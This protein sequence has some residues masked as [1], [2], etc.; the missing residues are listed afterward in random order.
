MDNQK[1]YGMTVNVV[2]GKTYWQIG[3]YE[4]IADLVNHVKRYSKG[5]KHIV[6]YQEN[7]QNELVFVEH[8]NAGT[9]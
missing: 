8:L 5:R 6:V 3:G 9:Y 2:G 1:F 7:E 4:S